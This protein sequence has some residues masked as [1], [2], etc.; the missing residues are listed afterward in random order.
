[1]A[2]SVA[3]IQVRVTPRAVRSELL[4]RE[5]NTLHLRVAAPPVDGAANRAVT[6]LVA[7][8]I[9]VPKSAVR[10]GRGAAG[11]EKAL[12][13]RGLAQNEVWARLDAR[14]SAVRSSR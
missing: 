13:V 5:G 14:L 7:D 8:A 10:V 1:M 9:D 3:R 11:R 12:E 6:E 2:D 4:R